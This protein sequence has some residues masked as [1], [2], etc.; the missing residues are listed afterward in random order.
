MDT[1]LVIVIIILV[2]AI[3]FVGFSVSGSNNQE[4]GGQKSYPKNQ[5]YGGSC[6]R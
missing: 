2:I 5:Y 1:T 3:L 6:G 4:A